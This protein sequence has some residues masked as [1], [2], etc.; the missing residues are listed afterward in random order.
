MTIRENQGHG[1]LLAFKHG[2]AHAPNTLHARRFLPGEGYQF[3]L[4][5]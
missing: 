5:N 3:L 2:D 1:V 4:E